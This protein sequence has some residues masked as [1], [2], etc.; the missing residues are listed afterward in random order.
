LNLA[1]E[2]PAGSADQAAS[3]AAPLPASAGPLEQDF[4]QAMGGL[5]QQYQ[6]LMTERLASLQAAAQ[7]VQAGTLSEAVRQ[8]GMQAAHKLA[9]VLGMFECDQGTAI[10]R[11]LETL[12]EASPTPAADTVVDLVQQL[13]AQMALSAQPA[14]ANSE[15]VA[16]LLVTLEADLS[17]ELQALAAAA[18]LS[19]VEATTLAEAQALV[20]QRQPARVVL[21]I[22]SASQ[23][24]ESLAFLQSL[25]AQAP[26]VS[27]LALTTLDSLVD[28]V[29][30][31]RALTGQLGPTGSQRLLV[32]PVTAAQV[33]SQ[34]TSDWR[35]GPAAHARVLVVDDDPLIPAALRPLL[36]PWGLGVVALENPQRFWEVLNAA[37]PDL[38]I[39]DVEMPQFSGIDLCQAVRV[40]PH[41]QNLPILFLTAHQDRDTVQQVFAAGADDFITKPIVGP[42]L[43]TRILNRLERN[44][45]LQALSRRDPLTGLLNYAQ[46]RPALTTLLQQTAV[47]ALALLKLTDL[48]TLQTHYGPETVHQIL[49][50]WG[51]QVQA[52][53]RSSDIAGYWGNGEIV[54]GLAGLN[55]LEAADYLAPLCQRL[56][57]HIVT[58]PTGERLQPELAIALAEYPKDSPDLFSL[59]QTAASTAHK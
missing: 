36:E 32:K 14:A 30:I 45:L 46:S 10:A 42:E 15:P 9:G 21:E 25:T 29:A 8:S 19:W 48:N 55:K 5:W 39:L 11:Q 28:R 51:S 58:L 7:A 44:Q 33:W 20:Q 6:G 26:P 47:A 13:A 54:V 23:W 40:D 1:E 27:A 18:D 38:L 57:Q 52:V 43:L 37:A 49:Q 3:P 56:R 16:L 41:W 12:L 34:L 22:A 4:R 31:A 17:A 53:L 2:A 59:Y 50:Y 35:P 24:A